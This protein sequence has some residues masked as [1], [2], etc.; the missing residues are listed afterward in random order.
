V[1]EAAARPWPTGTAICVLSVVD[2]GRWEGLPTLIE[3][4]KRE[5]K[6]LVETA[7][8]K[9]DRPG[10]EVFSAVQSGGFNRSWIA[11]QTWI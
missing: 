1:N 2:M 9:L 8:E 11:W 5:A 7:T 4:A 6:T 10:R 3:D